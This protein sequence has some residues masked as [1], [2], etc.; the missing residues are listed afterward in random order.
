MK[1]LLASAVL[2]T[3]LLSFSTAPN[4]AVF[5]FQAWVTANGEQG[6][7]N[8]TPFTMTGSGLTLTAKAFENSVSGI[9]SNVYMDGF[10]NGAVGGMGVCS[11]LVT[12]NQCSPSSDDNVSLDGGNAEILSWNFSQN[13]SQINLELGDSEHVTFNSSFKYSLNGV[14]WL[15]AATD[16]NGM[17]TLLLTGSTSQID[18]KTSGAALTDYFYIRNADVT[19]VPVPAA[20][21]LFGSGL[22]GLVGVARK[23]A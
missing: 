18:F 9:N 14:D 20:A 15:T 4:A 5:D 6:F 7:N 22:L 1:R 17:V 13:V 16:I 8:S 2:T 12:G 23:R 19:V 3:G 10:F 21:F 11:T